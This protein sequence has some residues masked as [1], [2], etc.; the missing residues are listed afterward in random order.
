MSFLFVE[1]TNTSSPARVVRGREKI[2]WQ[3]ALKFDCWLVQEFGTSKNQKI[4]LFFNFFRELP[5]FFG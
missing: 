3:E 5:G 2:D 1:K 4:A